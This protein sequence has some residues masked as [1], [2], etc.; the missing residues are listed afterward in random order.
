[1]L[2]SSLSGPR[3]IAIGNNEMSAIVSIKCALLPLAF[4]L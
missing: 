2:S 3:S 1:M 4:L